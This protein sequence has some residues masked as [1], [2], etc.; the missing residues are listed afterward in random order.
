MAPSTA[1]WSSRDPPDRPF[2][3]DA[4]DFDELVPVVF[5][6]LRG[7]AYADHGPTVSQ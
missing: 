4:L 5:S 7:M 6:E 2:R 3:T 1:D